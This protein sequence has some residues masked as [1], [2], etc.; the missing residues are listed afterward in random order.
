MGLLSQY[1]D[2]ATGWTTQE[3]FNS[4]QGTRNFFLLQISSPAVGPI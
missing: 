2:K 1:E 4:Q 3:S